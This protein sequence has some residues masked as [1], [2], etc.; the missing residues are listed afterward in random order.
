[1]NSG[2]AAMR[3]RIEKLN[4]VEWKFEAA[5]DL[6]LRSFAKENAVAT[7]TIDSHA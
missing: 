7:T 4:R 3:R 1:M 2:D 5:V 6:G